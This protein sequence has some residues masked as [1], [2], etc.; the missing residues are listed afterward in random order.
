MPTAI[1]A[2]NFVLCLLGSQNFVVIY[3]VSLLVSPGQLAGHFA[4]LLDGHLVGQLAG[5]PAGLLV[6]QL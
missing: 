4:G 2:R 3:H 1:L 5:H 6:G